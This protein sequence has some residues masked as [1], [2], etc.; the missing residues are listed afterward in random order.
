MRALET[1]PGEI[2]EPR[3]PSGPCDALGSISARRT[4]SEQREGPNGKSTQHLKER[5]MPAWLARGRRLCTNVPEDSTELGS[6][7][8]K[9]QQQAKDKTLQPLQQ[10]SIGRILDDSWPRKARV[11]QEVA[12]RSYIVGTEDGRLL[13][14]DRQH[15]LQTQGKYRR[16]DEDDD[17]S[18]DENS[19]SKTKE[20]SFQ[21]KA[22][23]HPVSLVIRKPRDRSSPKW[24]RWKQC[25]AS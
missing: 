4:F 19:S 14:W 11:L 5:N 22:K 24:R 13:R 12:L 1:R 23:V 9:H 2:A 25:A 7:T 6:P 15:L 20:R 16:I 18:N 17:N 8:V 21:K 3:T 10:G